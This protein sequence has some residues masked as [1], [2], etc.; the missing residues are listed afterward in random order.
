MTIRAAT[1]TAAGIAVATLLVA[2]LLTGNSPMP[3]PEPT[4]ATAQGA[5][6]TQSGE[7]EAP[8]VHSPE[9][10]RAMRILDNGCTYNQRGIPGCGTLLGAAYGSNTDPAAW[11]RKMGHRLG[12]HRTYFNGSE[13]D[14]AVAQ[15]RDD[16]AHQRIPWISFKL[17]H[18]WA[19]MAAG[20]GDSWTLDLSHRL[21]RLPGPVWVAFHHEPE[22]DGNIRD[23][24]KMQNRLAPIVRGAAP[25]VA[26]S[27]ILSGWNQLYGEHQYRLPSLWPETTIDLVGF[28]VYNKYGVMKNGRRITTHTQ[29]K[30][31]YFA[32][33]EHFAQSHGVAWGLA[34]TGQT[35]L[36]ASEDPLFV[37]H[38][39]NSVNEHGGV[40]MAYFNS[41]VNSIAPWRLEGA[42]DAD[43]AA[44]LRETPTL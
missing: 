19:A 21:A 30:Q 10:R 2:L 36:A 32:R 13:V 29:F 43:F 40:A 37:Q 27:V 9:K 25:N 41:T 39:Y 34:E 11:E 26:F 33:F 35:D 8:H 17:P 28:D 15:A 23:W 6:T 1:A 5:G 3:R 18:S 16:L 4:A 12:V 24:T 14:E 22:G 44:T 20:E 7:S 42:K 31:H 38:L